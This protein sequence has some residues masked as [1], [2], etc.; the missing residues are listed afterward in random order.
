MNPPGWQEHAGQNG[1][2]CLKGQQTS[3]ASTGADVLLDV[4]DVYVQIETTNEEDDLENV[5][6]HHLVE[7]GDISSVVGKM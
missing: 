2:G 3:V 1:A 4:A 6:G 5:S 7:S